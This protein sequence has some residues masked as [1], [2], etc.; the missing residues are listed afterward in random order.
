LPRYHCMGMGVGGGLAGG[1]YL[2][3]PG[4]LRKAGGRTAFPSRLSSADESRMTTRRSLLESAIERLAAAGVEDARRNA[5]WMMGEALGVNRAALLAHPTEPVPTPAFKLFESMMARRL[6]REP[7]QYVL[8]HTDFFGLRMRVTRDVLI[9]RPETE[10]LV[11]E[12]LRAIDPI[13]APWVLDVGTGS[14]AIA[15]A[16]KHV[17]RDAEVFACDIS[18]PA[19]AVATGNA[20][21]LD[22]P[23]TFIHTDVLSPA[24]A[25]GV[26]ACF[27]L[28][29]SNPPYVPAIDRDEMQPEVR[30]FEPHEALFPGDD[31]LRFYRAIAGHAERLLKRGRALVVETHVDFAEDVEGLFETAGLVNMG[32]RPD[33]AGRDRIVW[34]ERPA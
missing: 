25:D 6:R 21:R 17:R 3:P 13:D 20:E 15:L 9:P 23:V 28:M 10:E 19:L 16:I 22:L 32:R 8:G 14:G 24:F 31:P 7:L 26:P 12:A 18:E 5:E 33:L 27:D 11:E 4:R 29:V 1:L 30:D 2:C 34:G